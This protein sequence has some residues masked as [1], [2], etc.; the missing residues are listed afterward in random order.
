[1]YNKLLIVISYYLDRFLLLSYPPPPVWG[2]GSCSPFPILS[3]TPL[4][5]AHF[6]TISAY[7]S[8]PYW[9]RM[10]WISVFLQFPQTHNV[11]NNRAVLPQNTQHYNLHSA[12]TFKSGLHT[13]TPL[14]WSQY[15]MSENRIVVWAIYPQHFTSCIHYMPGKAQ[16]PFQVMFG[17]TCL[18]GC[19]QPCKSLL[20]ACQLYPVWKGFVWGAQVWHRWEVAG[21]QCS[22][23][24]DGAEHSSMSH[25]FSACIMGLWKHFTC[26]WSYSSKTY[27]SLKFSEMSLNPE[28]LPLLW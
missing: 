13:A 6:V 24:Q 10:D 8:S 12:F 16:I 4:L 5:W 21:R 28:H 22:F 1:M 3:T 26:L 25:S 19:K 15:L 14:C 27:F 20:C 2:K 7:L 23:C 9:L 17:L 11:G 18:S